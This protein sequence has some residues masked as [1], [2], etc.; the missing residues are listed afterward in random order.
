MA[1]RCQNRIGWGRRVTSSGL[2]IRRAAVAKPSRGGITH[3]EYKL[4]AI[5]YAWVEQQRVVLATPIKQWCDL[6]VERGLVKP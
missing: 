4:L 1:R 3:V 6:L 5:Q 2:V